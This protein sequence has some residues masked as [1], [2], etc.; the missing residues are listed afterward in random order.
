[1]RDINVNQHPSGSGILWAG[2]GRTEPKFFEKKGLTNSQ[3]CAIISTEVKDRG[4]DGK[5]HPKERN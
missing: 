4:N 1:M 2:D 3:T 5:P